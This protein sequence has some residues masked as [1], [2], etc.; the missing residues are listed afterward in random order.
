VASRLL[1]LGSFVNNQ[2]KSKSTHMKL[3][4]RT[5]LIIV[6]VLAFGACFL[7]SAN[8]VPTPLL[9]GTG[10]PGVNPGINTTNQF[11]NG[12]TLLASQTSAFFS[13]GNL[14]GTVNSWV[15]RNDPAN[16]L[17][18]LTFVYRVNN[19]PGADAVEFF[20]PGGFAGF[21]LFV[22]QSNAPGAGTVPINPGVARNGSGDIVL[23]GWS[24]VAT[25]MPGQSSMYLILYSNAGSFVQG[26]GGV[27]DNGGATVNIFTASVP[28]GGSALVLLG[29]GLVAIEGLRRKLATR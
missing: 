3:Q 20:T 16:L 10:A 1:Y 18:G 13:P 23:F 29:V 2:K 26:T 9:P 14:N 4:N 22:D 21:T 19:V 8:A 15:F 28:E 17:G 25:I 6:A 27:I 7:N 11:T 24:S 5:S 12:A